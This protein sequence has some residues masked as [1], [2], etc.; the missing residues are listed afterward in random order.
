ML[1]RF[2]PL[3]LLRQKFRQPQSRFNI[4]LIQ[5]QT[6]AQFSNSL[7]KPSAQTVRLCEVEPRRRQTWLQCKCF[8][9]AGDG[10]VQT[11]RRLIG[12]TEV[13]MGFGETWL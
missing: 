12:I 11:F 3:P 8:L 2:G 10:F 9:I 4:G 1:R 6:M 13:V 5:H 7:G